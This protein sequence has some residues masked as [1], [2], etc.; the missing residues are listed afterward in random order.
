MLRY[1]IALGAPASSEELTTVFG[2]GPPGPPM[3]TGRHRY[4]YY[5]FEQKE[6]LPEDDKVLGQ[7]SSVLTRMKFR[8]DRWVDHC[9]E[10]GWIDP[11]PAGTA[12]YVSE[13]ECGCHRST[14]FSILCCACCWTPPPKDWEA[15]DSLRDSDPRRSWSL[16]GRLC[17]G[18]CPAGG[19]EG[20]T[21]PLQETSRK[22]PLQS[23]GQRVSAA[24]GVRAGAPA[25]QDARSDDSP[26]AGASH[27]Q[28]GSTDVVE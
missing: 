22:N 23:R 20:E 12:C 18:C 9:S 25:Q 8:L 17:C 11:S 13:H 2:H 14:C 28:Y 7:N 6:R 3:N 4:I 10:R 1:N 24:S 19:V 21:D 16:C 26:R 27:S 15:R 5:A